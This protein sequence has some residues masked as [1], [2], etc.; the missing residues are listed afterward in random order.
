MGY[1]MTNHRSSG[2]VVPK[3]SYPDYVHHVTGRLRVQAAQLRDNPIALA[4]LHRELSAL[5]GVR[6]VSTKPIIGSITTEYVPGIELVAVRDAFRDRGIEIGDVIKLPEAGAKAA[7]LASP[8][9]SV[10]A[11]GMAAHFLLDLLVWGI[12]ATALLTR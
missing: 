3:R 12:A 4:D 11:A 8:W 5:A 9:R 10:L 1:V 7:Q 6:R 2:P